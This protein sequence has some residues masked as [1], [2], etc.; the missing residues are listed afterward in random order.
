MSGRVSVPTVLRIAA[1][2]F[3]ESVRDKVLYAIVL[4]AVLII[5]ASLLLGQLTAGQEVKIIK[6]LGL[7]AISLFGH[8]IA[9]FIGIGLVSKEVDRRSIYA[10]LA[11]P[12]SRAEFVL[13]KFLGLLSTLS[14][15]VVVMTV[16]LIVVLGV[17]GAT[18]PAEVKAAWEA[19]AVDPALGVAA[20]LILA[21]LAVVTAIALCFSTFTSPVLAS[22]F[23][24][25]LVIAGH[26]SADLKNFEQVVDNPV[27]AGLA[28]GF[29]YVL[30]NLAPFDVKAQ[31][32]HALPITPLYVALTT[33]YGVLY[34]GALLTLAVLFF[35]RRDFK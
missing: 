35:S 9:I 14:V 1:N 28:R 17:Y 13:G 15:N 24:V 4:F 18:Q 2:V 33:G 12:M 26:F 30:P 21:E 23:S 32:V 11:K 29:Y 34:V 22:A 8:F 3:K 16:A 20:F 10:L 7:A 6:D 27:A 5:A 31:V 19:P 25:G